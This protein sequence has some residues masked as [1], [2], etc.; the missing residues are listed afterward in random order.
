MAIGIVSDDELFDEVNRT[1][2]SLDRRKKVVEVEIGEVVIQERPGRKEGDVNVPDSLRKLIG[3]ES[4]INGRR[5]GLELAKELKI[6]PSSV[7]AYS[8]GA[9]STSSYDSPKPS[10]LEHIKASKERA[11]K[12]ASNKLNLALSELTPEKLSNEK[13]RDL[14]GI[15]KDMSAII[16]N[17][18]PD[19]SN[20]IDPNLPKFVVFAPQFVS[21][22]NFETIIVNE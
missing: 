13:A 19:N 1:T 10:I 6:S 11:I 7:S 15:A 20:Q 21:E 9:A 4:A 2:L 18:E 5:N 12:R 22:K 17:L 14:A 3:E 8:N 16:R